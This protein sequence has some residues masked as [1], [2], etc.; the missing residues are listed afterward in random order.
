M[1]Y[2]AI[3]VHS[4]ATIQ[5]ALEQTVSEMS[6]V[7]FQHFSEETAALEW[8]VEKGQHVDFVFLGWSVGRASR[9][10]VHALRDLKNTKNA[11][12]FR[13]ATPNDLDW[14]KGLFELGNQVDNLLIK[15]FPPESLNKLLSTALKQEM[16]P[17]SGVLLVDDDKRSREI[18]RQYLQHYGF[19]QVWEASDGA[20][21]FQLLEQKG[22]Q[23]AAIVS[24]WEMPHVN[25]IQFLKQVRDSEKFSAV[26]FVMITSQTSLEE[27]KNIQA[28][29][30][31]VDG[32]LNKPFDLTTF[33]GQMQAIFKEIQTHR[34]SESFLL[35]S[36]A[37]VAHGNS[38]EA[39]SLLQ[40]AVVQVP[41]S[42]TLFE[43]LGDALSSVDDANTKQSLTQA[44]DA[45]EKAIK[46]SSEKTQLLMKYFEV[47]M[48]LG[49]A[50]QAIQLL[51][52]H[53]G[54][55]GLNDQLRTRL[56]K[57][58][59]Q[60]GLYDLAL[61][62]LQRTLHLNPANTEAQSLYNLVIS[63]QSD[64]TRKAG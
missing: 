32:Y 58:Y 7:S 57:A 16:T 18:L 52:S 43:A 40:Q 49:H 39:V 54:K 21:A 31:G 61:T 46:L 45:Y 53:I 64:K 28:A 30:L 27:I 14:V 44:V 6:D 62:E 5:S 17:N 23:V 1:R 29:E 59:V 22:N 34:Q 11:L 2:F 35:H 20:E 4:D 55:Q 13:I 48:A 41:Q 38:H 25:G 15:P 24:D 9:T 26:P 8:L 12:I 3:T 42:A 63:L 56:A 37:L 47:Q 60:N 50:N 10:L 36:R 51:K 19:A 33:K